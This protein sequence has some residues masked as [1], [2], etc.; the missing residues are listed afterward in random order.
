MEWT[1]ELY[2]NQERFL[3]AGTN[4]ES[5]NTWGFYSYIDYKLNRRFSLSLLGG[6]SEFR[7]A[8]D[9]TAYQLGSALSFK[10]SERQRIRAQI[11]Y[12]DMQEWKNAVSR[13]IGLTTEDKKFW[14]FVL[15]WTVVMGSHTHT[16][17]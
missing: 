2:A 8:K 11:E 14:Q 13:A 4:V 9:A 3:K 15:Q 7:F 16:Y 12:I 5:Q 17:E 10:P 6:W 1:T